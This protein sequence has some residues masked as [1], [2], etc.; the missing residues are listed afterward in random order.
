MGVFRGFVVLPM[1]LAAIVEADAQEVSTPTNLAQSLTVPYCAD[2]TPDGACRKCVVP[3][4]AARIGDEGHYYD[5]ASCSGLSGAAH[6]RISLKATI[7]PDKNWDPVQCNIFGAVRAVE[8]VGAGAVPAA[9][10][11]RPFDFVQQ[12]V[13]TLNWTYPSSESDAPFVARSGIVFIRMMTDKC[14]DALA[15]RTACNVTGEVT[16]STQ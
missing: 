13:A 16:I 2:L 5:V 15:E 6:V 7:S 14:Q 10:A 3:I 4:N 11:P 1:L 9:T 12:C 8:G